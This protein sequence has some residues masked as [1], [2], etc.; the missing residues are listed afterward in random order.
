M[1]T[2]I[3]FLTDNVIGYR[4][5]LVCFVV[6]LSNRMKVSILSPLFQTNQG[7]ESLLVFFNDKLKI[8]ESLFKINR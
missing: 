7:R 6:D 4:C 2:L 5:R 3:S 1:D 8:I